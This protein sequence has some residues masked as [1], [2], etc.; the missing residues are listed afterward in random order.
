MIPIEALK[1]A[2]KKEEASIKL[3]TDMAAKHSMLKE[4]CAELLN[5]EF[6]HKKLIEQKIHE[7][8]KY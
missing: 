3:Y 1:I 7:L 4:L 6:K 5:E 2:L 8:T